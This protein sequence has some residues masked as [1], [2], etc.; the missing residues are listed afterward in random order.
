MKHLQV[1]PKRFLATLSSLT[2]PIEETLYIDFRQPS[3]SFLAS[4]GAGF[5]HR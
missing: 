5:G 4:N 2:E 3:I 1:R